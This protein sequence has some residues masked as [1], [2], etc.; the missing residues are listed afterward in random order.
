MQ[1]RIGLLIGLLWAQY[2]TP[3]LMSLAY[4]QAPLLHEPIGLNPAASLPSGHFSTS[5]SGT[6]YL[7]SPEIGFYTGGISYSWD[8]VQGIHVLLQRWSFDK[9]TQS[10]AGAG[11]ALRLLQNKLTLAVRGRLL[12]TNFSEYGRL[13]RFTPDAG[14][15]FKL[16][17]RLLIGGYGYNL[18][19]QGWGFL[20]GYTFYGVGIAYQPSPEAQVMTELTYTAGGPSQMRTAFI[21]APHPSIQLRGGVSLPILLVGAGLSIRYQRVAMDIGYS[22]QPTT[23]SWAGVGISMP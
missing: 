9:I 2:Y 20:P 8:T 22:Y 15:V 5:I 18:L 6:F 21:Y 19:A 7:P 17:P 1:G 10:E 14:F 4:T 13:Y 11:Y 23:G 16:S 12:S 3:R